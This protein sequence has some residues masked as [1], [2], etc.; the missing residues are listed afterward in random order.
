MAETKTLIQI[1]D[2]ITVR[3]LAGEMDASPIDVIMRP[4]WRSVTLIR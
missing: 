1:P 3:E 4:A 2:F